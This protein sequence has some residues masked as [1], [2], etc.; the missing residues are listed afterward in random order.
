ME[1]LSYLWFVDSKQQ[2]LPPS[3]L[4]ASSPVSIDD[5]V[6]EK[7]NTKLHG[8]FLDSNNNEVKKKKEGQRKKWM[9]FRDGI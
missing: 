2:W 6:K 3:I 5:S 9:H 7:N 1:L 8:M 4:D